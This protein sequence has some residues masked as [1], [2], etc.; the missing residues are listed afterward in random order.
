MTTRQF[1][2]KKRVLSIKWHS[3]DRTHQCNF[4][5]QREVFIGRSTE[6]DIVLSDPQVSRQHAFLVHSDD[7][8][9]IINYSRIN[10]I[11]VRRQGREHQLGY[12]ENMR[13]ELGDIF[14]IGPTEFEVSDDG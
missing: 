5:Q 9:H 2:E 7:T 4:Q 12:S 10:S 6:S 11:Y 3:H 8:L 13:L 1:M 14:R